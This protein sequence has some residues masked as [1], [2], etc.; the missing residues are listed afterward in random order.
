MLTEILRSV[1]ETRATAAAALIAVASVILPASAEAQYFGR[2]KVQYE[3]FD[4]RVLGSTHFDAHFYPAESLAANDAVRMAERW[5]TRLSPLL[6]Y[7]FAKRPLVFYANHPDFQQTNVISGEISE[8]TGGVTES[9][10][11]RVILPFTGVYADNDHVLGHELVHVFQYGISDSLLRRPEVINGVEQ[12]G[13][14]GIQSLPLWL[15]EG[16]A[17]YLSIG[18][19]DAH[20]AMWLRDA[21]LRNQLPTI[22][23]LTTDSRFFPYRYGEALWAY[24]G[25]RYGDDRIGPLYAAAVRQGFEPAIRRVLGISHDSLSKEWHAAIRSAYTPL[26]EGMVGP[27]DA[28][29]RV[30]PSGRTL[31]GT[32]EVSPALSPDGRFV[33]FLSSRNLVSIDLVVADVETGRIVKT[34]T[35]PNAD[36]HFSSLSFISAAGSWSP[37]GKQLVYVTVAEGDNRIAIF[38]VGDGKIVRQYGIPDVEAINDAAWGPSGQIAFAGMKGGISDLYLLDPVTGKTRQLTDDRYAELQPTWSPDGRTLAFAT[39]RGEETSFERL[40]FGRMRLATLEVATLAVRLLPAF[41]GAKHINPQYSPDGRDLFFISDRDGFSNVYR[42]TLADSSTAQVTRL[43]TGVSGITALSP[44]LTVASKSGRMA[45]SV[46]HDASQLL[47]RLDE[48]Q[49]RGTPF[50]VGRMA[51]ETVEDPAI[52]VAAILPPATPVWNSRVASYLTDA[53]TGLFPADSITSRPLSRKL[54]LEYLG[55]PTIGIGTSAFGTSVGGSIQ[56]YFSD[57]LNNNMVGTTLYSEGGLLGIGGE[58]FYMNQHRRLNW[59]VG[60]AHIPYVVGA[61]ALVR[62]TI[63]SRGGQQ[64]RAR[65]YEQQLGR[66]YLD[67]ASLMGRYPLS[68]TR[69]IELGASLNRQS[70]GIESFRT[71]VVGNSVVDEN[72]DDGSGMD[73][74][75]YG[76][77]NIA[78]VGDYSSFGFTSPIAGGRY[79][80]EFSP[81]VGD[82]SVN[83]VL[84]DYRRYLFLK[85]VTFAFRGM[86][87]GRYGA[88][89]E[90][91]AW[92]QPLFV[93][94]SS[95]VRGYSPESFS[96]SECSA[97]GGN[98]GGCPEFDQLIG[99]RIGV[100]SAEMRIPLLGP[101]AMALVPFFLPTEVAPFVDAGVAWT[102]DQAPT[103]DFASVT[104]GGRTP[105]FSAGVST[106]FN[107][108]GALV[109]DVFYAYPF[110]RLEKGGHWGFQLQP[111]W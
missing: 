82:L 14:G 2:N 1:R 110:Q 77:A 49:A 56:A 57:M 15:I 37:D 70:F 19:T 11:N 105:V 104:D 63:I 106:R 103:L 88:D 32:M 18:R 6:G 33:A 34:L 101:R 42:M 100:A 26:M 4:F 25:G 91:N 73:P 75:R 31:A 71:V 22:R 69:R 95:L 35:T 28:G 99:S 13:G 40:S 54:S 96:S 93:G 45:F 59:G 85:P 66:I 46:F 9:L 39:D 8:G 68:T 76:Q 94:Y 102:R 3:T 43:A 107:M 60:A 7:S 52:A 89:A 36:N 87:F 81:M 53:T 24:I 80:F 55:A 67:Q 50:T 58:A 78:Y 98:V 29:A 23:Q 51:D 61:G 48:A 10:R 62:D 64:M 30:V 84:A 5:Y 90:T 86:H 47:F 44:A 21:V 92:M 41:E 38:D 111:G 72:R 109:L 74:V 79:R 27:L 16:M 83:T 65:V 20:T 97:I 17:E 12:D 108:F